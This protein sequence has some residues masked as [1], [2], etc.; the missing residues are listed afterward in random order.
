MLTK[1]F[2]L[3]TTGLIPILSPEVAESSW[4]DFSAYAASLSCLI[5]MAKSGGGVV[6]RGGIGSLAVVILLSGRR[7]VCERRSVSKTAPRSGT[8]F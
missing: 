1:S 3:N 6:P 8:R 4:V 7:S 2:T 5:F